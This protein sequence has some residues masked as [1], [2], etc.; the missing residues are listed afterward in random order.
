MGLGRV[1]KASLSR[2]FQMKTDDVI[3]CLWDGG[4]THCNMWT[5]F[6]WLTLWLGSERL[7]LLR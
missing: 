4:D 2:R 1:S 3:S 6:R 5:I 7:V